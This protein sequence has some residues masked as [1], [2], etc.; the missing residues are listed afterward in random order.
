MIENEGVCAED[1]H[2]CLLCGSEGMLLYG[3]LRDRL[4]GAP[5]SWSLMQCPE[6]QLVWLNPRPIPEDVGKLYV[7]YFTHQKLDLQKGALAGF[8]KRVKASILDSSFGYRIDGSNRAGSLLSRIGPLRDMAGGGV[9]WLEAAEKGRL[10]DVGCGNGSFLIQMKQ[11]GWEVTGV[12][13]D[14]EAVSVARE[15]FRLNVFK[16]SL[17]E[18]EFPDGHFD[19][20]TMNHVIE[21]VLDP[22][23]LLK[24]CRRVLRPGGKLVVVTPNIKSL[25]RRVFEDAWLHWDPPRHLFLFSLETLRESA[26]QAGLVIQDLRTT[27]K[28]ARVIWTASSLIRRN[29]ILPG[30]SPESKD[31]WLG[32]QGLAYQVIE[33]GM[34]GRRDAG[35]E[36]ILIATK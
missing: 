27:A 23:G 3:G 25:G 9:M 2:S 29:G 35:E 4:F 24:E 1:S 19:T 15:N 20:I 30:G 36:L 14:G 28:G 8:R 33:Y 34:S 6:C 21:H 12:E 5:G 11:L 16:G 10:L 31:H 32:V 7:Q 26:E 17:E 22:I 18:A 13:P